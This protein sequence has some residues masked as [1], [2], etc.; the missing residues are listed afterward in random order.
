MASTGGVSPR[1]P[2]TASRMRRKFS[3]SLWNSLSS[4]WKF[5]ASS[6]QPGS[7]SVSQAERSGCLCQAPASPPGPEE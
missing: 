2:A 1:L 7:S 4:F 6:R 3:S 5:W